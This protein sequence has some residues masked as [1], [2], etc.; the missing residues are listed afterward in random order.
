[1]TIFV[2]PFAGAWIEIKVS[3]QN[4]RIIE[5]APFAGA[6]IEIVVV[7]SFF[8]APSSRSL[9]GSVDWNKNTCHSSLILHRRSLRG[10]VDWNKNPKS[11]RQLAT[12]R[13]LRGSVDWNPTA[14]GICSEVA[15]RSLRGSVDWNNTNYAQIN[16]AVVA[17]FAGAW[18][19]IIGVNS[20]FYGN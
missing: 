8:C 9:R 18:I 13:S 3:W 1:M 6:W 10:S 20:K 4:R 15:S 5:V 16:N 2:A 17:P 11:R 19:E 7:L 12:G 14:D